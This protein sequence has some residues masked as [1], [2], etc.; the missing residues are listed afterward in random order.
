MLVI[1]VFSVLAHALR[2]IHCLSRQ[3]AIT[4]V[5]FHAL[6]AVVPSKVRKIFKLYIYQR[7]IRI[8]TF[9]VFSL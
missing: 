5:Y 6:V 8:T 1:G 2:I 3:Y 9:F 4:V 7:S